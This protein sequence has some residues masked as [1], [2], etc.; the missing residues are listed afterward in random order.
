MNAADGNLVE[1]VETIEEYSSS[2]VPTR[3]CRA[4]KIQWNSDMLAD[5][6]K[7]T[8]DQPAGRRRR[9]RTVYHIKPNGQ[10]GTTARR[11]PPDDFIYAWQTL[12]RA[13]TERT[14]ETETSTTGY[15]LD[16]SR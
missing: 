1:T 2:R 6:P 14:L 8:S 13:T 10:V 11:S 15:E 9:R 16:A 5:E 3:S 4:A 7:V 12:E